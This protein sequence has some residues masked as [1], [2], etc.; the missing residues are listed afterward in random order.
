MVNNK[1]VYVLKLGFIKLLSQLYIDSA[2]VS[3]TA[4]CLLLGVRKSSLK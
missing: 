1:L 2:S 3:I 4:V